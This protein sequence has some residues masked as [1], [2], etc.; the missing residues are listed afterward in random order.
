MGRCHAQQAYRHTTTMADEDVE[1]HRARDGMANTDHQSTCCVH[2]ER[3]QNK[4]RPTCVQSI[5]H[6]VDEAQA[7]ITLDKAMGIA[8]DV[9][10]STR[11][12]AEQAWWQLSLCMECWRT[13]QTQ[14]TGE[15]G[16]YGHLQMLR[17][18]CQ[19]THLHDCK[20]C[21][22]AN[23]SPHAIHQHHGKLANQKHTHRRLRSAAHVSAA[24]RRD[25]LSR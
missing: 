19:A 21:G 5:A 8:T 23:Q 4:P 14:A 9:P 10:W 15:T 6:H 1:P 11:S 16:G 7:F 20:V 2:T 24:H 3:E 13:R 25:V 17:S 22:H 18:D 12:G